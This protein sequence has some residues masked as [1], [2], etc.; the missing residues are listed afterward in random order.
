MESRKPRKNLHIGQLIFDNCGM[1]YS[2]GWKKRI[3]AIFLFHQN[4]TEKVKK[5]V[6]F[7]KKTRKSYASKIVS[8][9]ILKGVF[10]VKI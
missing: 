3:S 1:T 9:E 10:Q 7:L 5:L 2:K 4:Y 8:Q 6:D